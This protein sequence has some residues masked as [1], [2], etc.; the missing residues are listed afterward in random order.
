MRKYFTLGISISVFRH[1]IQSELNTCACVYGQELYEKSLVRVEDCSLPAG[2]LEVQT[3]LK[4]PQV[5]TFAP[6][7]PADALFKSCPFTRIWCFQNLVK[8]MSL[9]QSRDLVGVYG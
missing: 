6:E 7:Q 3:F 5:N 4:V 9:C 1:D 8:V 2:L